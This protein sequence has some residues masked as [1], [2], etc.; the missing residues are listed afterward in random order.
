MVV[1][2]AVGL[3][4]L[5][6]PNATRGDADPPDG[7]D[8]GVEGAIET[9]AACSEGA[10]I[11]Y[12]GVDGEHVRFRCSWTWLGWPSVTASA[13]CGPS[14]AGKVWYVGDFRD[15]SITRVRCGATD[16]P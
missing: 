4:V 2:T 12:S 8:P 7:V 11:T 6:L 5:F 9:T 3:V 1:A 15:V 10:R 14:V 13:S 16:A